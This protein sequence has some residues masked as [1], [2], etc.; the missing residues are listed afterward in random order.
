MRKV[1]LQLPARENNVVRILLGKI[2]TEPWKVTIMHK[3]NSQRE[4]RKS[5]I[6]RKIYLF[7]PVFFCRF[8]IICVNHKGAGAG[9][10]ALYRSIVLLF[11]GVFIAFSIA[12]RKN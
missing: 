6:L 8:L 11:S 5:G 7:L 2:E 12:G 10:S 3:I 1:A 9:S 4:T